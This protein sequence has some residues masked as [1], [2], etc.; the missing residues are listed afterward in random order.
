MELLTRVGRSH[1]GGGGGSSDSNKY[2]DVRKTAAE[3]IRHGLFRRFQLS[4]I[5]NV[6]GIHRWSY[7]S[8][9]LLSLRSII[10]LT[11]QTHQKFNLLPKV[12]PLL[13]CTYVV[14]GRSKQVP[15][16]YLKYGNTYVFITIINTKNKIKLHNI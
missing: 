5:Q 11:P 14:N 16:M 8:F 15:D 9:R 10:R 1:C 6:G 13:D 7:V 4:K 12:C 2:N 3:I